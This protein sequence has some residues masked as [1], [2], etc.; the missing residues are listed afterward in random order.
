VRK[1]GGVDNGRLYAMKVLKKSVKPKE[2]ERIIAERDILEK[3]GGCPFLVGLHYAF[4][5]R[6]H[7]HLVMGEYIKLYTLLQE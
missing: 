1:T 7:L 5:T 6:T 3:A 2:K 4:Q